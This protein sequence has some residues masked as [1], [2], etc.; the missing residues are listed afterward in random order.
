M[1]P[2][3]EHFLTQAGP[4]EMTMDD[5]RVICAVNQHYYFDPQTARAFKATFPRNPILLNGFAYVYET[6]A[7]GPKPADGRKINIVQVR[8]SDCYVRRV[9]STQSKKAANAEWAAIEQAAKEGKQC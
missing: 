6:Q 7:A 9:F 4:F 3:Q 2:L 5:L 8:L 1:T